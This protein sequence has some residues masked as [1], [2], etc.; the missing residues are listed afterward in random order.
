VDKVDF[1]HCL[2]GADLVPEEMEVDAL[3][4]P[5][6]SSVLSVIHFFKN[7]PEVI[8]FVKRMP[9]VAACSLGPVLVQIGKGLV[10]A[11]AV[12]CLL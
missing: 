4:D 8:E 12:E 9:N 10:I 7:W 5:E 6:S 2:D 11:V 1:I 3:I